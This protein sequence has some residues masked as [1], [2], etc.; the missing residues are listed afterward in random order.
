MEIAHAEQEKQIAREI[1]ELLLKARQS[2]KNEIMALAR[3]YSA[4]ATQQIKKQTALCKL[5]ESQLQLL[6][7]RDCPELIIYSLKMRKNE[8][9]SW[10][11]EISS[12]KGIIPFLPVIPFHYLGVYSQILM[13]RHNERTGDVISSRVLKFISDIADIVDT[14]KYPYYIFNVEDGSEILPGAFDAARILDKRCRSPLTAA[15]GLMLD[16]QYDMLS[17]HLLR[18]IGSRTT[19]GNHYFY[20]L[21]G[22]N[23]GPKADYRAEYFKTDMRWGTP[24]CATRLIS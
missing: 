5:F 11:K 15:E 4:D 2:R 3:E 21:L 12:P 24:S 18:M 20:L 19:V 22:D 14:P 13:L 1:A 6:R 16:I 8:V 10:A 7:K 23:D 9:I 17:K